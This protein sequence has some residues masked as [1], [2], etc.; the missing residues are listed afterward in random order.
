VRFV[1]FFDVGGVCPFFDALHRCPR[2]ADGEEMAS[3]ARAELDDNREKLEALEARLVKALT[4]RD[5]AD[6]KGVVLEVRAGTGRTRLATT[7]TCRSRLC[8]QRRCRP[9]YA[10]FPTPLTRGR[11]GVVVR[12]RGL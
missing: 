4:P 2:G 10:I 5:D 8:S 9:P 11:R 7:T 1:T 12:R 6:D 3:L